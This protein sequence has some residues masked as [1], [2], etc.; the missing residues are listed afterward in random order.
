MS[1]ELALHPEFQTNDR[2]SPTEGLAGVA[3]QGAVL[4]KGEMEVVTTALGTTLY[5]PQS[6]D[7]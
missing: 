6:D 5:I 1:I 3:T 2:L 4:K 7:E